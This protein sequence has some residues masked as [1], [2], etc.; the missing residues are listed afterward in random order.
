ML[1]PPWGSLPNGHV[2]WPL[3]PRVSPFCSCAHDTGVRAPEAISDLASNAGGLCNGNMS[4]QWYNQ[5]RRVQHAR[6]PGA[7][8]ETGKPFRYSCFRFRCDTADPKEKRRAGGSAA[9]SP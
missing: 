8:R 9:R 1:S 2:L 4:V 5:Q 7:G 6:E 3:N